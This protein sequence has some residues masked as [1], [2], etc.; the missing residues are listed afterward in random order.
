MSIVEA[1]MVDGPNEALNV[2]ALW[3]LSGSA[4]SVTQGLL[5]AQQML[6]RPVCDTWS[7][8][9]TVGVESAA[10]ELGNICVDYHSMIDLEEWVAPAG[11]VPDCPALAVL[12]DA[13]YV[14]LRIPLQ[15]GHGG[16]LLRAPRNPCAPL[17]SPLARY[18]VMEREGR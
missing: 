1:A 15:F 18:V 3:M 9:I 5:W 2:A 17:L 12:Q 10:R 7:S 4:H 6:Y 14:G 13:A 16:W 11:Q 8:M